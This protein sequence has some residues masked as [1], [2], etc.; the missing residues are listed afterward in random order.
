MEIFSH[1]MTDYPRYRFAFDTVRNEVVLHYHDG[2]NDAKVYLD[3][4]LIK[5]LKDYAERAGVM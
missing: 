1:G 5:E 4:D 2:L 3:G